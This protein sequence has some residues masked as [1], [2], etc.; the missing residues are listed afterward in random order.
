MKEIAASIII[1]AGTIMLIA[2]EHFDSVLFWVIIFLMD[3]YFVIPVSMFFP[4]WL[5]RLLAMTNTMSKRAS[6]Q[7]SKKCTPA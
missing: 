5:N 2:G 4:S 3:G 6:K 1:L 7:A